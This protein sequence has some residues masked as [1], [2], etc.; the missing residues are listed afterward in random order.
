MVA[1]DC[2]FAASVIVCAFDDGR[3]AD[4]RSAIDS[5]SRQSRAVDE[6]IVVI[7]HNRELL[8]RAQAE[9][10]TAGA[11]GQSLS[12]CTYCG[13]LYGRDRVIRGY[14]ENDRFI[15]ASR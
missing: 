15:A 6:L 11:E 14:F 2:R 7:D 13:C 1:E 8:R 10:E 12:V 9:L 5:L 4:L 3:W